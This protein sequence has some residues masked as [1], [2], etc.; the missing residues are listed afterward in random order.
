MVEGVFQHPANVKHNHPEK[1]IHPCQFPIELVDRMVLSTTNEQDIVLDPFAGVSSSLI[2][3]ILRNRRACGAEVVPKYVGVS[4]LRIERAL[5]GELPIRPTGSPVYS[6]NG[7]NVAQLPT[8]F[9]EAR[10]L[11][12]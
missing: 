12:K 1:T 7:E 11:C 3:A 5:N 9:A 10:M 6:P 2:A 8:E 4:R